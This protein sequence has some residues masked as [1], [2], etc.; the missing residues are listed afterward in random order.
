MRVGD[1]IHEATLGGPGLRAYAY[2]ADVYCPDCAR[3]IIEALAP[4]LAGELD[5]GTEDPLFSDSDTLPQPCF[6][7]EA[8]TAQH[9]ADC[10]EYLYGPEPD[11]A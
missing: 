8:D 2:R 1:L 11:E 7:P 3:A 9:C 6:F 4:E 10:G 5:D